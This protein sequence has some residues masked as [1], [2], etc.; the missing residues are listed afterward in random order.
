MCQHLWDC[1]CSQ[2]DMPIR[3]LELGESQL[4]TSPC[5]L[6]RGP[7]YAYKRIFPFIVLEVVSLF[8]VPR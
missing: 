1:I 2:A 5:F 4:K 6:Y 7:E 3:I 8:W